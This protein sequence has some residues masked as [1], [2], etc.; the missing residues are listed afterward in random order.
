MRVGGVP[1]RR[2]GGAATGCVRPV[3][4]ATNKAKNSA[5]CAM[6]LGDQEISEVV[7]VNEIVVLLVGINDRLALLVDD[8]INTTMA[9]TWIN[10]TTAWGWRARG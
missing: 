5:S 2:G 6:L 10:N 3:S 4:F 9:C 7:E 8:W 1:A